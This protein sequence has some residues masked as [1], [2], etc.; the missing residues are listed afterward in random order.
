MNIFFRQTSRLSSRSLRFYYFTFISNDVEKKKKYIEIK[1]DCQ[2]ISSSIEKE[3]KKNTFI[4]SDKITTSS[5][6]N[7]S[8]KFKKKK[9]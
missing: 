9:Q 2:H 1:K 6:S 7:N 3:I 8:Q 5:I 4:L